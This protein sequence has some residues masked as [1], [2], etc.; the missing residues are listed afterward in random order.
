[1]WL[2]ALLVALPLIEIGLLVTL[3]GAIGLWLTLAWV[4]GTGVAGVAVIRAQG[5]RGLVDL[6][7]EADLI[8]NPLAPLAHGALKML[9]GLLLILPGFLTDALGLLLLIPAL[10]GLLI[11]ALARRI[12]VSGGFTGAPRRESEAE[13]IEAEFTVITPEDREKPPPS[14]WTRS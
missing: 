12:K 6:R 2:F 11:S 4:I 1:M 5:A 14:G 10:R 7:R 8:R 9:A 13:V 3:G